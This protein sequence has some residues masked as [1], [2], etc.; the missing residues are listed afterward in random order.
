MNQY[1]QSSFYLLYLESYENCSQNNDL[2]KLQDSEM[3][4]KSSK[5]Y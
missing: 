2:E 4:S 3:F 1:R 5:K